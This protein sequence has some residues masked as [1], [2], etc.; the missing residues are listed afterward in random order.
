MLN[1]LIAGIFGLEAPIASMPEVIDE[2]GH[3]EFDKDGKKGL[4]I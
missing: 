4:T 2:V 3:C 1:L